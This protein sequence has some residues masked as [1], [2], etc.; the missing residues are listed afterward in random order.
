MNICFLSNY[1]RT[2]FFEKI[3]DGLAGSGINVFWI[4]A[5]R[6]W[7]DELI[8]RGTAPDRILCLA[9]FK[10]EWL[11]AAPPPAADN[12][13]LAWLEDGGIAVNDLILMDRELRKRRYGKTYIAVIT[14]EI[15]RFLARHDI[16]AAFGEGTWAYEQVTAHLC[17]REGREYLAPYTIRVPA[18]RF[19]FFRG[20]TVADL[21]ELRPPVEADRAAAATVLEA[22]KTRAY[23]PYY[24]HLQNKVRHFRRHWLGEA[25]LQSFSNVTAGDETLPTV[26][27]RCRW[28]FSRIVNTYRVRWQKPFVK[29]GIPGD[30]PFVLVTLHMQPEASIDVLASRNANQIENIRTLSRLLPQGWEIYVKEHSN[31]IGVRSP[32]Y[33]RELQRI[34]GVRLVDPYADTFR[35]IDAA[36]LVLSPTGTVSFEAGLLGTRA[37]TLAP[38]Y[39]G[40]VMTP[41]MITLPTLAAHEFQQL[42]DHGRAASDP[43]AFL[44]WLYAQSYPGRVSD[45]VHDPASMSPDNISTVVDGFRALLDVIAARRQPNASAA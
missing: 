27:D 28:R 20:T 37:A 22:L 39:F 7:A 30:R 45:P 31:A 43:E 32:R 34:P 12:P 23:R 14:R 24:Y 33:Y 2:L 41:G 36:R 10:A 11:G 8:R 21:F 29:E 44:A 13:D 1:Y 16:R 25:V 19:G 4:A 3:A 42:L 6:R 5:S 17:A 18:D 38:M 40:P 35:L 15:R 26:M 9:D